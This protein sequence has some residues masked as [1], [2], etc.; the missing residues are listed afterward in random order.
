MT[1]T[2]N[3][4]PS[5]LITQIIKKEINQMLDAN[6]DPMQMIFKIKDL[7]ELLKSQELQNIEAALRHGYM[8]P[9][10]WALELEVYDHIR[11]RYKEEIMTYDEYHKALKSM[12]FFKKNFGIKDGNNE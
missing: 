10:R 11:M 2:N 7:L 9:D 12:E 4:A 5:L 1:T 6:E 3:N 8:M